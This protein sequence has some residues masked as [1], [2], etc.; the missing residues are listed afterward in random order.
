MSTYKRLPVT[1]ERGEGAWLWDTD[2]KKYLD[3]LSGVAV[4]GL[5]HAHPAVAE[6]LC[7]QARR[8]VHSSNL[9]GVAKQQQLAER[10]TRLSGMDKAFFCNSGAEANEAAIKL[11]RLYGHNKG[12]DVPTIV[13]AQNSFHGRT[14]ATLTATGSRK[15]QAGFEPLVRG[16]LRVA[17][18]DLEALHTIAKN[19]PDVVAVLLEPVQGE[20]G[21]NVP[22]DDY[23][24]GV[25]ALCD[26]QGWLMLLD[27]VQTGM[28]R[29][30]KWFAFQ[31]TGI[32][33]D[34]MTLAKGLANGVPIGACVARGA[35]AEVFKPG[36]H[37]TTFGGNPLACSA[38]LAVLDVIEKDNLPAR[39]A[40]LSERMVDRLR[41]RL[42]A[43]C[44]IVDDIRSLG[45]MIGIE[46]ERPCAELVDKALQRGLL[47][48][49]TAERV[50]RLLP[51][52]IIS[53]A[54]ADQ[55]TDT[56]AELVMDF[57]QG[58]DA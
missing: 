42:T 34:V 47:I 12:I 49:V 56:V 1:F 10:L 43:D 39:A 19:S 2:G 8:L 6:A 51:P 22:D 54:E 27:E 52:L 29:T 5:G 9:Y 55:I 32:V 15:A 24:A 41:Q 46:L 44:K 11:A 57:A 31:H 37:A 20:G 53:E 26:Q 28:G 35:A 18:N 17:Y 30:G 58:S 25:R 13:V 21:V 50:I 7:D 3:A 14:L 16:F 38:A 48:N 40:A 45:L 36:S 4:C 23:L 33:P